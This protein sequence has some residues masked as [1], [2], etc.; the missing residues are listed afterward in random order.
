MKGVL[1]SMKPVFKVMLVLGALVAS[2]I[3]WQLVFNDGGILKKGYNS[4]ANGVNRQYEKVAGA[5]ET[6]LPLWDETGADDNGAG[7]DIDTTP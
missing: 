2:F 3:V 4:F 1:T 7:F 6:I 5:G